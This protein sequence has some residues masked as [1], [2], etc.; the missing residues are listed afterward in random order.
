MNRK[1]KQLIGAALLLLS[2][3]ILGTVLSCKKAEVIDHKEDANKSPI[4]AILDSVNIDKLYMTIRQLSGE[5]P[6]LNNN[7][8]DTIATRYSNS[9]QFYKS[10]N[11]VESRFEQMGYT[12]ELFPF[13]SKMEFRD[14]EFAPDNPKIGW[15][16]SEGKIYGTNDGGKNWYVQLSNMGTIFNS[17]CS[18]DEKTAWV[19]GNDGSILKTVDGATWIRESS[20]TTED[21]R[22]VKFLNSQMGWICGDKGIIL[23]SIDGGNNWRIISSPR[24]DDLISIYFVDDKNGW[25][26]GT[27][28]T[29]IYSGDSGTTWTSQFSGA[30]EGPFLNAVYFINDT[31]GFA[32]GW[33][34]IVLKTIDGGS[35]W[36]DADSTISKDNGY[37]DIDFSGPYNGMILGVNGAGYRTTDGGRTWE[38]INNSG[39][40]SLF[41]LDMIDDKTIWVAGN[42]RLMQSID[43][44]ITWT[45]QISNIHENIINNVY[46]IKKGKSFPD[47]YYIICA[48]YDAVSQ[49]PMTRTPGADDN[50]SGTATVIEAA[51]ILSKY[52]FQYSIQF[53]LFAGE[54][55]GMVGSHAY[56]SYAK[57]NGKQIKGVINLDMIGYDGNNDKIMGISSGADK[58][59]QDIGNMIETKIIEWNLP[60]INDYSDGGGS[61]HQSFWDNGFPAILI[62]E[63][64][65]YQ[66]PFTHTTND[67]LANFQPDYFLANAKLAIGGIA[68][69]AKLVTLP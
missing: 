32:V 9:P 26:V 6:F 20:P 63:D 57:V 37:Q 61:D 38:S 16:T 24:N 7:Q 58:A 40:T 44:G 67:I 68:T 46:A 60:L 51:R 23:K 28:E 10:Q 45:S 8:L 43:S 12:A 29:I 3:L 11:Y 62:I 49:T 34:G 54:E 39:Q 48:H 33:P 65:P 22:C 41:C 42:N 5:E 19:I 1:L 53:M 36:V 17:V 64:H 18:I 2:F 59:S 55:Q 50:A 30:N 56:A 15:L 31:T 66:N 25:A 21:L 13:T 35:D 69:L 52:D 14:I 4:P 27:N 47:E